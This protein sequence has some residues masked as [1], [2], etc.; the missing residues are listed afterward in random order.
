MKE[1]KDLHLP[2]REEPHFKVLYFVSSM[3]GE[4]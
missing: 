4:F 3:H 1:M 2:Q